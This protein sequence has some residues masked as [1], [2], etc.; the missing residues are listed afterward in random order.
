MYIKSIVAAIAGLT[1]AGAAMA[2]GHAP[3]ATQNTHTAAQNAMAQGNS[4][5]PAHTMKLAGGKISVGGMA[6]IAGNWSSKTNYAGVPQWYGQSAGGSSSNIYINNA[7]LF[8][9][10]DLGMAH[11]RINIGYFDNPVSA[12]VGQSTLGNIRGANNFTVDE[13]Y[14]TFSNFA[15]SPFY[16]KVGKSYEQFGNYNAYAIVPSLTQLFTEVS[17][18]GVEGG[19]AGANGFHAS[20][21]GFSGDVSGTNVH[22][23]RN[24]VDN[25]TINAGFQGMMNG[26]DFAVN[27][28]YLNDSRDLNALAEHDAVTSGA[29]TTTKSSVFDA[30]AHVAMNNFDAHVDYARFNKAF[31]VGSNA[32]VGKPWALGVGV[33][34][35]FNTMQ[36]AS[37]V[38]IGYQM[39]KKS[40][41]LG[42]PK[43]R[44]SADYSVAL[45]KNVNVMVAYYH[46]KNY[47]VAVQNTNNA[48]SNN[49]VAARVSV[50]F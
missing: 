42:V 5:W 48:N 13:A 24:R 26:T 10:G 20:I 32:S 14:V 49:M 1:V 37:H 25:Y 16:V 3:V 19:Y 28:G 8:L 30:N 27:L 2:A 6:T 9:G 43:H 21:A 12:A 29:V 45:S 22:N 31:G 47:D 7:N 33:G 35:K 34:Y 4:V 11:A 18:T 46:D 40:I 23:S 38:G 41:L 44:Y 15:K 36:Y 17:G 50:S 39:T